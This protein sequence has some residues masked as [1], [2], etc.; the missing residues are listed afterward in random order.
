[1]SEAVE[2]TSSLCDKLLDYVY[3]E[4]AG[5]EL[6]QF[7]LHLLTCEKCKRELAGLERVR[8]AVKNAMPA[9]EPPVDK[10]AQLLHAA[11]QQKPKRGK[12]LMFARRMVSHPA[13]AA[14]AVFVVVGTAVLLNFSMGKVMMPA[15]EVAHEE[16]PLAQPAAPTALPP[17]ANPLNGVEE[18]AAPPKAMDAPK[19]LEATL[20]K[21]K[22]AEP[23]I[24]LKTE[25]NSYAVRREAKKEDS[26]DDAKMQ[27][28]LGDTRKLHMS[29]S[30]STGA[31]GGEAPR[32][33]AGKSVDGLMGDS[34]G[35]SEGS[36]YGAP[37]APPPPPAKPAPV[38]AKVAAAQPKPEV[39]KPVTRP[40][41]SRDE[42]LAK[43]QQ[44]RAEGPP[45][46]VQGPAQQYQAP[47]EERN[48]RA[49]QAGQVAQNQAPGRGAPATAAAP[50]PTAETESPALTVPPQTKSPEKS[51]NLD[52]SNYDYKQQKSNAPLL[53]KKF[54]EAAQ[55]GRCDE[56]QKT[57][58]QLDKEYPGYVSVKEKAELARC[59]RVDNNAQEQMAEE[60][61]VSAPHA[62]KKAAPAKAKSK[63]SSAPADTATK[64]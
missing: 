21:D 47:M 12:V 1:M 58:E 35:G 55:S 45:S 46:R 59:T 60:S 32:H 43:E 40:D 44:A 17:P 20:D 5:D 6:E 36:G 34:L 3:G 15:P 4:L 56:A 63:P 39:A 54:M 48:N 2:N 26:F 53:K 25:P 61:R 28:A 19:P 52:N 24:I 51:A 29:T 31:A 62:A 38:Q 57:L 50:A 22:A 13:L 10:M 14:A 37:A 30:V 41:P 49:I 11:A 8:S 42:T 33:K 9:V 18:K 27:P 16:V 64:K 7:K 23:K